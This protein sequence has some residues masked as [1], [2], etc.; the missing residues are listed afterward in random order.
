METVGKHRHRLIA[1]LSFRNQD[2]AMQQ[3]SRRRL[4]AL[5]GSQHKERQ[6]CPE[7]I[8]FSFHHIISL[9]C[10]KGPKISSFSTIFPNKK[11]VLIH[12]SISPNIFSKLF[13]ILGQ[14]LFVY[15]FYF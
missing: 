7:Y 1:L 3:R 5:A 14:I 2:V 4:S 9:S 13:S 6:E 12:F 8:C 15:S 10:C 11:S